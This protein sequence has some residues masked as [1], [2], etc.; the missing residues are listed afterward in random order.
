MERL[1]AEA[2]EFIFNCP[3][4]RHFC[5][6]SPLT[7]G[8]EVNNKDLPLSRVDLHGLYVKEASLYAERAI[9]Q[10]RQRGD[11]KVHL[12]VGACVAH[13]RQL[14]LPMLR[15]SG[16]GKRSQDKIAVIKPA[17][18]RLAK[19]SVGRIYNI[20]LIVKYGADHS[21]RVSKALG[22]SQTSVLGTTACSS[23]NS[24]TPNDLKPVYVQSHGRPLYTYYGWRTVP[25]SCCTHIS[26]KYDRTTN[27]N[28]YYATAT[29]LKE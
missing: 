1:N 22:L 9:L 26:T 13:L 28:I 2:S 10:A 16:K 17:M 19:R 4:F 25:P 15:L 5:V 18:E 12:I 24:M 7:V 6:T 14:C 23:S 21:V 3:F 8:C 29:T 20:S 27:D 11:P